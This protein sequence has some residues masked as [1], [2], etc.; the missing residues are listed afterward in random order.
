MEENE[1]NKF[2]LKILNQFLYVSIITSILLLLYV[3]YNLQIYS[4]IKYTKLNIKCL[5]LLL[6][7]II[8]FAISFTIYFIM[9]LWI[10]MNKK[11]DKNFKDD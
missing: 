10:F 9:R 11:S 2:N 3:F 4:L 1:E 5:L 7:L 8:P 6:V